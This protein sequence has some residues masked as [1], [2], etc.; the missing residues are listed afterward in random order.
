MPQS[1]RTPG[2][3]PFAL[4][5]AIAAVLASPAGVASAPTP[6][7]QVWIDAATHNNINDPTLGGMGRFAQGLM[8]RNKS[9]VRFPTTEHPGGTGLYLDVAAYSRNKPGAQAEDDIPAALGLGGT[10]VLVPP[11]PVTPSHG[12]TSVTNPPDVEFTVREYWGCGMAIGA[13]Q[14]RVSTFRIKGGVAIESGGGVVP[15]QF[16]PEGD[17]QPTPSHVLWPNELQSTR[18][19]EG[20]SLA[21]AHRFRGEGIPASLRFD[22]D[23]NADFMPKIELTSQGEDGAPVQLNWQSVDRA[24]AYF[25]QA[26]QMTVPVRQGMNQFDVVVWSSA[27]AGG[28]G[29][30]L[31]DYLGPSQIDRWLKQK[32]LLPASTTTCTVPQGIFN[33]G[34]GPGNMAVLNMVAYG[35]ETHLAYP[36]R[37][38]DA[39][40]L[41]AWK[42]EWSVRVRT[43]STASL[44]LGMDADESTQGDRKDGRARRMLRGLFG[45]DK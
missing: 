36:P 24:K 17:V 38:T 18:V 21:G 45:R 22:L 44:I 34:D 43:K 20:A 25:L 16:A 42:P 32:L 40:K 23:R 19:P 7:T 33:A 10:L 29:A 39:K 13:G 2:A 15:G 27:Q 6:P 28:A 9:T 41:A 35:P 11:S 4:T 31:I 12:S 1:P 26:A 14:P 8:E 37:P 5:L 3:A 30:T